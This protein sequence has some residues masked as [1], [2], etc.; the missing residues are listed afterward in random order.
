MHTNV[1]TTECT[2]QRENKLNL[3]EVLS[4]GEIGLE[5]M[6]FR[7]LDWFDGRFGPYVHVNCVDGVSSIYPCP[8]LRTDLE[9]NF[10]GCQTQKMD[11]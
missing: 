4:A 1:T 5:L 2:R 7:N 9:S 6:E 3:Q 8:N 10:V 11:D